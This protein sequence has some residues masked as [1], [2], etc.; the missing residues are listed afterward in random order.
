MIL[1]LIETIDQLAM[2]NIVHY[3]GHILTSQ[4]GRILRRAID[5]E[6]DVQRT[7][8]RLKTAWNKRVEAEG[9]K[10][11]L[12]MEDTLCHSKLIVV[13]DQLTTRLR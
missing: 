1:G 2:A 11:D 13:I 8:W 3:Y 7:K 10:V 6:V 9:M 12:R 4:D 5:F